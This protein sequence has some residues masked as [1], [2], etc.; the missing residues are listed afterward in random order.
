[1]AHTVTTKSDT[2]KF[3][4]ALPELPKGSGGAMAEKYG[5]VLPEL[6]ANPGA[7]AEI[8]TGITPADR[9]L[10]DKIRGYFRGQGYET[11][12]VRTGKDETRRWSV[13]VRAT[14]AE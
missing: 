8:A 2:V 5:H 4:D 6:D 3:V 1:M 11:R 10:V 13:Y 12:T 9:S 7:W 14:A